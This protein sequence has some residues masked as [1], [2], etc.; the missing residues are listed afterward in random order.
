MEATHTQIKRLQDTIW[1]YYV[2][3][4]PRSLNSLRLTTNFSHELIYRYDLIWSVSPTIA[5]RTTR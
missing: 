2:E 4:F 1:N 5:V 3:L